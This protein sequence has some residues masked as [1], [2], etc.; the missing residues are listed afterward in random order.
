MQQKTINDDVD[1]FI[2]E[3]YVLIADFL[4][5]RELGRSR[6]IFIPFKSQVIVFDI[7]NHKGRID[8]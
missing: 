7:L 5:C 1:S 8:N 2:V 4:S 3:T 6:N